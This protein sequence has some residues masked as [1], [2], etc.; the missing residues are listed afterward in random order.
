MFYIQ[1]LLKLNRFFRSKI[2]I[3]MERVES[4]MPQRSGE[5]ELIDSKKIVV[6]KIRLCTY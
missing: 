4:N 2:F 3:T 5:F 1:Y 6:T